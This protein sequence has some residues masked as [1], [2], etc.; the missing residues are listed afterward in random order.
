MIHDFGEFASCEGDFFPLILQGRHI[1]VTPIM[2][3]YPL[4]KFHWGAALKYQS[5]HN[6]KLVSVDLN[7]KD[8]C[9]IF[10][11]IRAVSRTMILTSNFQPNAQ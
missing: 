2:Y 9:L 8:K 5:P 10:A 3:M 11:C 4:C 7:N 1:S 6:F